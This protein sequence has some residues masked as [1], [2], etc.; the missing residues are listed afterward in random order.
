MASVNFFADHLRNLLSNPAAIA[1][2]PG[3]QF[4]MDQGTRAVQRS[5]RG[6]RG[7]GNALVALQKFGQG[8]AATRRGEEIDRMGGLLGQEQQYDLGERAATT[9]AGRLSLDDRLG[10]G[11]LAL[12]SRVADG[13][14]AV[15]RDALAFQREDAARRDGTVRRGQDFEFDLGGRRLDNDFALGG[16]RIG[17]DLQQGWWNYDLGGRRLDV[18]SARN[19]NEFNLARERAGVDRYDARTRRGVAR[20]NDWYTRQR[21]RRE[22]IPFRDPWSLY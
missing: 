14:L 13:R 9:A 19:E 11:R 18:D 10:T 16:A 17:A 5:Q 22:D 21:N 1:G 20:T 8:L 15:D 4:E 12:D 2:T 3:Y 7:S 6:M